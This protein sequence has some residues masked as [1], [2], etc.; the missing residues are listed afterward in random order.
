MTTDDAQRLATIE[1]SELDSTSDI[2]AISRQCLALGANTESEELRAWALRKLTRYGGIH[3]P[4]DV[5]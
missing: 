4:V 5:R 1:A 2:A 3:S